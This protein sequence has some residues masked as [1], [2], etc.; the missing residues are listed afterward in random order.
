MPIKGNKLKLIWS[1]LEEL[2]SYS[3]VIKQVSGFY[4]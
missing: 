1:K 2:K 3:N 4:P